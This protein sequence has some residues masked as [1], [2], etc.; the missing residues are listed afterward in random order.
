MKLTW[1]PNSISIAVAIAM[2]ELG[3]DYEPIRVNFQTAEQTKPEYHKINPKGRVPALIL[4]G[5][6]LTE[7]G[8]ILDYLGQITG[9]LVPTDPIQ[10]ARMR[11]A[12]YYFAS[13]FH[14][15][16]AHRMRG[17]R[18][19][20][21]PESHADM[22]AKVP[23]TIAQSC[24]YLEAAYPLDPFLLGDK[25]TLADCYLSVMLT[26]LEGDGVDIDAT[27]KLAAYR[28]RMLARPSVLKVREMGMLT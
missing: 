12:M 25:M 24:A 18:W 6:I 10:V 14:V 19:A 27:P 22:A 11:E 21:S 5:T 23:Q 7:T 3:L 1:S 4:D 2:A 15:N 28:E 9:R 8:A 20:D 26:W 16:H 13:T 17:T